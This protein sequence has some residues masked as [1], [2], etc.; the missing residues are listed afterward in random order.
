[1]DILLNRAELRMK[2][3]KAVP[4][5]VEGVFQ[6]FIDENFSRKPATSRP[7]VESIIEHAG[8]I[9]TNPD[10]LDA[11]HNAAELIRLYLTSLL[12]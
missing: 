4:I 2:A 1:M 3:I 10:V 6:S 12:Y 5:D 11:N 8:I 9:V 7:L